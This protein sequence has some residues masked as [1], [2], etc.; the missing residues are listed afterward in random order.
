MVNLRAGSEAYRLLRRPKNAVRQ[1]PKNDDLGHV[2]S[3]LAGGIE[4]ALNMDVGR[5]P[6]LEIEQLY[7][8]RLKTAEG[9]SRANHLKRRDDS[10]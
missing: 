10:Q 1:A 6:I 3:H 7:G 4:E 8:P 5:G 9:T 2:A